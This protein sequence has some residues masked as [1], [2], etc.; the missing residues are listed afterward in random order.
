MLLHTRLLLLRVCSAQAT[1]WSY[2]IPLIILQKIQA[3]SR[4]AG[5]DILFLLELWWFLWIHWSSKVL[6]TYQ[7]AFSL[8]D[9][10]HFPMWAHHLSRSYNSPVGWVKIEPSGETPAVHYWCGKRSVLI[11]TIFQRFPSLMFGS[12]SILLFS[13]STEWL[14]QP[15]KLGSRQGP[16]RAKYYDLPTFHLLLPA[17]AMKT[18]HSLV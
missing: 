12:T 15:L 11:G 14:E 1:F 10:L 17:H 4:A 6:K 8:R 13:F 5:E 3:A 18:A 16:L 2:D 9:V 7:I